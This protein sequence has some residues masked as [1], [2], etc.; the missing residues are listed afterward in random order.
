MDRGRLL[1]ALDFSP[2]NE[3]LLEEALLAH[4]EALGV[5][6]YSRPQAGMRF[7]RDPLSQKVLAQSALPGWVC[8]EQDGN[9]RFDWILAKDGGT[10]KTRSGNGDLAETACR[11]I[12]RAAAGV[13]AETLRT[14]PGVRV[15]DRHTVRLQSISTLD[16]LMWSDELAAIPSEASL[17]KRFLDGERTGAIRDSKD[18]VYHGHEG[19]YHNVERDVLLPQASLSLLEAPM[20]ITRWTFATVHEQFGRQP[21]R[22][23]DPPVA[24]VMAV[25]PVADPSM[26]EWTRTRTALFVPER[27]LVEA[28][29]AR[30]EASAVLD[31]SAVLSAFADAK[32]WPANGDWMLVS[33]LDDGTAKYGIAPFGAGVRVTNA[34][35][36][37]G[38]ILREIGD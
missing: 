30:I 23:I 8:A 17:T 18:G 22:V 27:E 37:C 38:A 5:A 25:I 20:W 2:E 26:D 14:L 16:G 11:E 33:C 6:S 7:P 35:G 28:T 1:L 9:Y 21:D 24:I 13:E 34:Q 31:P 12:Q 32:L 15:Q 4:L 29:L 19:R 10:R 3:A 36:A